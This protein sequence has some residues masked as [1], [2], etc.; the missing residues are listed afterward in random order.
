M[1]VVNLEISGFR[2]YETLT[3]FDFKNKEKGPA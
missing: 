2:Q 3:A 1:E